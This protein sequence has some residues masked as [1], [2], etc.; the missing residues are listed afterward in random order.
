MLQV[1]YFTPVHINKVVLYKRKIKVVT[2]QPPLGLDERPVLSVHLV[3]ESAGIAQVVTSAVAAPQRRRGGPA[4]HAL[5][6]FWRWK[7]MPIL[8][9]YRCNTSQ[10]IFRRHHEFNFNTCLQLPT[11]LEFLKI[12]ITCCSC[13]QKY[14][15]NFFHFE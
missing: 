3:V 7:E 9:I 11:F 6:A 12:K 1:I 2:Y 5:A 10:C 13:Y 8:V 4:V 15:G 14:H